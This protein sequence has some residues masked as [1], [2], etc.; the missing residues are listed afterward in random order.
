MPT[1]ASQLHQHEADWPAQM[2]Q[3]I[4][5]QRLGLTTETGAAGHAT[6]RGGAAGGYQEAVTEGGSLAGQPGHDIGRCWWR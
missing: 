6:E 3:A 2:L 4:S 1:D 5:A